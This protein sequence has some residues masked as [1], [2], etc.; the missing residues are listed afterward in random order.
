MAG[1]SD[2]VIQK[3]LIGLSANTL[4]EKHTLQC[5]A[6]NNHDIKR[7]GLKI[8][9]REG[10]NSLTQFQQKP[11]QWENLWFAIIVHYCASLCDIVSTV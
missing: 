10:N 2:K 9:Q 7:Y 1:Y 4:I 5:N 11:S 6:T 8:C 3:C